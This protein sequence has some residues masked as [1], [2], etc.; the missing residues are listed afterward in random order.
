[1]KPPRRRF[2]SLAAGIA[3]LPAVSRIAQAQAY[4]VRPPRIVV[5]VPPGGT[6][7]IVAR[8]IGQWLS[9]RFGQQFIIE[10]RPGAGTNI[11]TDVVAH[12]P[13]DGYTLLLA[14]SPA[15][16]NAT[17]YDN[18][19]FNFIRDIAPVA[20]IERMPLIM[21]VNPTLPAK[22][23]PE[24]IGYAKASPGRINMGS[25]GVGSTGHVAGA[26]FS[27]TAGLKIA[28]V[29][30]R[31]EAPAL[32]DLIGAQ[33][34]VVFATAGSVIQ[35]VR[36][37]A[38]RALAVTAGRPLDALPDVPSLADFLPGYEASAWAGIGAPVN[39]PVEI[40]ARLN[41]EINAALADPQIKAQLADLGA[42]VLAGSPADFGKFIA[43]ETEKWSKVVKF[44]G[45]KP[46]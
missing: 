34:Q 45:A 23:V 10:N 33:V 17:L 8:L 42:T 3:V 41:K 14:G 32:T 30:Y 20:G 24:F 7:D 44:S 4:P 18:L 21:A 35:Y 36:S 5:G 9:E 38:L 37:G 13:A 25:G 46:N 40:V 22:T 39:T 27:M 19:N 31:G 28:H 12:A 26:L 6:F 43:D 11:G 16:I 15:A 29:P 1:M 2:L